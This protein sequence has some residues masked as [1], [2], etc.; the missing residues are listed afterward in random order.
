MGR[1]GLRVDPTLLR[2]LPSTVGGEPAVEAA[3]I[4]ARALDDQNLPASVEGLAA[5]RVGSIGDANWLVV[6]IV[7]LTPAA[8]TDSFFGSWS[9]EYAQGAC[10]QANGVGGTADQQIGDWTA[11]VAS[12]KGGVLAY[13]VRLENRLLLSATELGPRRLGH[14]LI[15]AIQ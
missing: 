2:S 8:N 10:S 13:T 7:R 11:R 4:E 5:A 6:T 3:D 14:Q 1:Y 9:D 15:E 12:C